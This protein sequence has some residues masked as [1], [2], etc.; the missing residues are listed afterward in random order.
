M[1]AIRSQIRSA[2]SRESR[3]CAG[4]APRARVGFGREDQRQRRRFR[5]AGRCRAAC[6][7]VS[8][9]PATSSTS[10][11]SWNARPIL[12][13]KSPSACASGAPS[14]AASDPSLQA[15]ANRLAVFSSQRASNARR[16]RSRVGVL[17]CTSSPRASARQAS[18]STRTCSRSSLR[19]SS[20]NAREKRKSPVAV[21]VSRPEAREDGRTPS[22]H[23]ARRRPRRRERAWPCGPARPRRPRAPAAPGGLR[24]RLAADED[25]QRPEALAARGQ[26]LPGRA[27][28]SG[29]VAG[30]DLGELLLHVVHRARGPARRRPQHLLERSRSTRSRGARSTVTVPTWMATMPPASSQVADLAQARHRASAP[31]AQARAGSGGPNPAGSCTRRG[32][33]RRVPSNGTRRSNQIAVEPAQ[34]RARRS[35]DLEYHDAAA[36]PHDA[37]HLRDPALAGRR[38]CERRNRPWRRRSSRSAKGSSSALP[39]T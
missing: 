3:C 35:R 11:S 4:P 20:E 28:S 19:P 14:P 8:V 27:P 30:G 9:G 1:A 22:A 16:R 38:G 26:R 18:E 29:P 39:C 34:G 7:C 25:Q 37:S 23:A 6:R 33:R 24:R 15:A 12:R 13:P 32:H 36:R 10:S 31:P 5:R 17:R 21:A 2:S